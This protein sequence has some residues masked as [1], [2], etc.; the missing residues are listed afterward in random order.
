MEYIVATVTF[1]APPTVKT[2]H[3]TCRMEHALHVRLAGPECIVNQVRIQ[4][5]KH[6]NN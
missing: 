1:P 6:V 3:V 5:G 2:T 4:Q